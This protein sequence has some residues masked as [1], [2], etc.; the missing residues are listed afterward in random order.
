M[1]KGFLF[2]LGIIFS[3]Q[4]ILLSGQTMP[5]NDPFAS[6]GNTFN[7][8]DNAFTPEEE[9]Y[10]GRAVAAN[11]LAIYK[12]YKQN[13][14]LTRYLNLICQTLVINSSRP[15]IYNGY[16]VTILD[17]PQIN[18]F[19]TPGG[20]IF[21][22]RGLIEKATS[23]DAL[24]AVIAHEFS[25]IILRHGISMVEE[26]MSVEEL[27]SIAGQAAAFSGGQ[28]EATKRLL[29][30][31]SSVSDFCDKMIKSGYS[32]PQEFAADN[33]AIAL[34]AA[35]GYDPRGLLEILSVL[36]KMPQNSKEGFFGTHPTPTQRITNAQ[37]LVSGYKVND[38]RSSR[39]ARFINK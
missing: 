5:S 28:N 35:S 11:I 9:Y 21:I 7:K 14:A 19:A 22:T 23:E 26:M 38:T 13:I 24:A 25:H 12:P 32:Q 31:R 8:I 37:G 27:N 1:K 20:H 16:H 18:A 34:L 15:S 30:F 2:F 6:M 3:M 36:Q 17:S 33:S 39:A 10:L 29:S 4:P